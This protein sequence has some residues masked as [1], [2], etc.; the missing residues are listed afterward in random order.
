MSK[1]K[2]Y[3]KGSDL[4]PHIFLIVTISGLLCAELYGMDMLWELKGDLKVLLA[5]S[6]VYVSIRF[7]IYCFRRYRLCG[8]SMRRIDK[9]TGVEFEEYLGLLYKKRGYKVMLTPATNDYGADL[10]IEKKNHRSV[11]QAKR[12]KSNVG[13]AAVQQAISARQYYDCDDAMVVT[14]SMFT[15][16]AKTLAGKCDIMLIDRTKLSKGRID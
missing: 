4:G 6:T 14:N 5:V 11:I 16:A 15:E 2:K 13:E 7:L 9:M 12:Y 3:K 8:A 1:T 10:I